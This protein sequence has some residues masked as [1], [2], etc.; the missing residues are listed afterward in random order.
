MIGTPFYVMKYVPGLV[1]KDPALPAH[2]P[3][4]RKVNIVYI[5]AHISVCVE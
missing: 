5:L 3:T 1:L 2:Q 4:Q